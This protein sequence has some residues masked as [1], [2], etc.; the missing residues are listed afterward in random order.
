M[1]SEYQMHMFTDIIL[2]LSHIL[3]GRPTC[4]IKEMRLI[5]TIIVFSRSYTTIGAFRFS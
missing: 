2:R 3:Y 5:Y 1:I 4:I